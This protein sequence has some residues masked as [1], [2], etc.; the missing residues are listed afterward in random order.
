[1]FEVEK[2]FVFGIGLIILGLALLFLFPLMWISVNLY[3]H[4]GLYT[5][6]KLGVPKIVG[7]VIF[8][9]IGLHMMKSSVKKKES[10]K[11]EKTTVFWVGLIILGVASLVLFDKI[12]FEV[13]IYP[14][15][16]EYILKFGLPTIVGTIIFILIGLYMMKSGVKRKVE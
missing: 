13:F 1:M 2:T 15:R 16:R 6:L 9:L 5:V 8:L 14:Y 4:C 12:W 7:I 10:G 11:G 3:H